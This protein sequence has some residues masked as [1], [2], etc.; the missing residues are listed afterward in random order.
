[1]SGA[2]EQDL[3]KMLV[4]VCNLLVIILAINGLMTIIQVITGAS[5]FFKPFMAPADPLTG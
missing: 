3:Q 2:F 5:F 4:K 1:M